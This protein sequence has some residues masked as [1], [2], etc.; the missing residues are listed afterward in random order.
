MTSLTA[1]LGTK[2][3]SRD[4]AEHVGDIHGVVVDVVASRVTA[5][6][7]GKGRKA[8]LVDQAHVTGIGDAVVIDDEAHLR[9]P[10]EGVEEQ[11]VKGH[12]VLLGSLVLAD[13]GT[14]RG[15]VVDVDIDPQTGALGIVA[16]ADGGYSPAQL[17]GLGAYALV[18]AAP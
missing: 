2:V 16:T 1:L 5:W 3:V 4:S 15:T 9:E 14:E 10:A 8:R 12:G 11:T 13:D 6:Q 7:V 17:R 18:V